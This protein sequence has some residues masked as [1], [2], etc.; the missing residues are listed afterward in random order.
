MEYPS[1]GVKLSRASSSFALAKEFLLDKL[2]RKT[3][4]WLIDSTYGLAR[5]R[6]RGLFYALLAGFFNKFKLASLKLLLVSLD[7]FEFFDVT[8]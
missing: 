1:A 5:M 2:R 7:F 6:P 8:T 3:S 4:F